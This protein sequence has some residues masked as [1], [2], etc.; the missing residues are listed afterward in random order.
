MHPTT[1]THWL[2]AASLLG[3]GAGAHA[4]QVWLEQAAAG[5]APVLRFGEFGENL[6]E[7][8]PGL[9]DKF[10]QPTAR[11]VSTG[12]SKQA[13]ARKTAGGFAQPFTPAPGE[14][15]VAE[16]A[17]YP[18]YT[19][20]QGD[21]STSNW[22]HPAARLVTS[23]APQAPLLT[24]DLVPAAEAGSFKLTF[25]GQP[26]AKTKVTLVTQSGWSKEERTD[27]E[28]LVRFDMPWQGPYVAEVSHND[29]TPGE[30]PGAQGAEKYDAVSYVTTL[31]YRKPEGI[32]PI[33][34]GPAATPNK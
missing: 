12:G 7:A 14:S 34:A 26:L 15:V 18:L 3:I 2:L 23:L 5:E 10:V 16:D 11:L 25:K 22:Y 32:A 1:K 29:R 9:L 20:R 27:A 4:H 13:D 30:R 24:L 33:P 28:G 8:S 19:S 31:S 6:R 17:R 21:K